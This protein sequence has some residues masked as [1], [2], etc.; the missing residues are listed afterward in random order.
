MD[1]PQISPRDVLRGPPR[2]DGR[3]A[4]SRRASSVEDYVASRPVLDERVLLA[5][6]DSLADGVVVADT[7]GRFLLFNP[8]AERMLRVGA[9]DVRLSD[10]QTAY[11]CFREDGVTPYATEDLPLARAIQGE[12]LHEC[13]M[14][15]R[16][17]HVPD[18]VWL[19][20]N[21][22]PV[23]DA[24]GAIRGGV[25]VFRDVTAHRREQERAQVLSA[26][27]EQTADCVVITNRYGAIEYVNPAVEATT[28]YAPGELIGATPRI[29]RS[30]LHTREF[31]AGMWAALLAGET[32]RGT[33]INRKKFGEIYYSQQTITP[34]RDSAGLV[35]RF[36]SVGKDITELRKAALRDSKL[37]LA[38]DVQQRLLPPAPSLD[39]RLEIAAGA[40]MADETGGDFY[41]F[42]PLADGRMGLVIGDVSGH[43]FDAALV[44][45]QTHAYFRSIARTRRDPCE[46]LSLFNQ[47][48]F[49][50]L[51]D[52]QYV[53]ALMASI[54]RD[55]GRLVYA[56]AGHPTGYALD[57]HGTILAVLESTGIPLGLFP[58]ACYTASEVRGLEPGSLV[59]LLTDGVVDTERADGSEFGADRVLEVIRSS[60]DQPAEQIVK[61][62]QGA[63]LEYA[64]SDGRRDDITVVV[65]RVL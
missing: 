30:D 55:A 5:I 53:T 18:G 9:L 58:E 37:Q 35:S 64:G 31:Y 48:I 46:I 21:G 42:I 28:G 38:R 20:I 22:S 4:I 25:I 54:D 6:L 10:W 24:S 33:I 11:G 16:N 52:N 56:S 36:V 8:A 3:P 29:F 47:A 32:F 44:M 14:L 51:L 43:G 12:T 39:C 40:L 13:Q 27:V 45:G 59:A 60:M 61:R 49:E 2:G 7:E 1:E 19:S 41:D 26:A 57:R 17:Q 65:C 50:D 63:V 34:I 62:V 23:L 15:I